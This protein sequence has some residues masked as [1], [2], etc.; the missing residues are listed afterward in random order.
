MT[1]LQFWKNALRDF[2]EP[3]IKTHSQIGLCYYTS[4]S[5]AN[6]KLFFRIMGKIDCEMARLNIDTICMDSVGTFSPIRIRFIK[7][8][9]RNLRKKQ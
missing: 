4:M 2:Q 6:D 1:E 3:D 9:I 5:N 8:M 7:R